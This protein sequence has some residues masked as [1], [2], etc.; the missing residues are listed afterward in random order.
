M[1]YVGQATNL[2]RRINTHLAA[3]RKGTHHNSHMQRAF[4]KYGDGVFAHHV[5]ETCSIHDLDKREQFWID[6]I[7]LPRLYNAA[8]IVG[9][10]RGVKYSADACAKIS[11]ARK[12]KPLSLEHRQKL[13]EAKKG[14]VRGPRS[15]D[16]KAKLSASGKNMSVETRARITEAHRLKMTGRKFSK[17]RIEKCRLANLGRVQTEA[18]KQK[19]AMSC[20]AFHANKR[21][22]LNG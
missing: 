6:T 5:L 7:G 3:L 17:E 4:H 21:M 22:S 1:F 2:R 19:R 15:E 10:T 12:G 14:K 13:S 16:T 11:A 18:E 8:P 20:L 9:S